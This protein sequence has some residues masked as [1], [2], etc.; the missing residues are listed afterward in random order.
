[1]TSTLLLL[2]E[3]LGGPGLPIPGAAVQAA[4]VAWPPGRSDSLPFSVA[5]ELPSSLGPPSKLLFI[6]HAA[7]KVS[8]LPKPLCLPLFSSPDG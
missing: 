1:M 2:E 5:G 8:L 6:L 7:T 4:P 3:I